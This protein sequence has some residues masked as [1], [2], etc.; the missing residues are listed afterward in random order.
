[1]TVR[2]I[3]EVMSTH[4][5]TNAKPGCQKNRLTPKVFSNFATPKVQTNPITIVKKN[6]GK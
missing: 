1:M 6:G 3:S 5:D 4:S 2:P